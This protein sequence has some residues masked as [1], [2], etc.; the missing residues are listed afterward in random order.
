MDWQ[1]CYQCQKEIQ[2]GEAYWSVNVHREMFEGRVITVLNATGVAV[3]CEDCA[4]NRDFDQIV[5]PLK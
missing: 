4:S 3:Y 1:E 5:V 2:P